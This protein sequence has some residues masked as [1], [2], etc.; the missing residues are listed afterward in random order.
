MKQTKTI[1]YEKIYDRHLLGC[2][3]FSEDGERVDSDEIAK[4]IK[5]LIDEFTLI[6]NDRS[7]TITVTFEEG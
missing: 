4:E 5:D 2:K 6:G 1:T 3:L 7:G